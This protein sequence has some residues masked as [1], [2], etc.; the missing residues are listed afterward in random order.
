[1]RASAAVLLGIALVLV[2]GSGD[3][4]KL[5]RCE[6]VSALK[7]HGITSDLRNWVCLVESES[8]GRTDKR[9][10]RNKN[11]SY[12]YGLFQINSKYWCGIGKVAGDCR[13]KCEDLLNNDL[14][15]DV[16]CA[17]KIFQ[18]HGFRGW[19]GWRNKCD[20]KSLPDVSRC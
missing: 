16:R 18:R 7:R 14:S 13:L 6:I 19:Y 9:G 5:Q 8:G 11:G 1:M 4:K 15:D 12:D 20:G 3:A 17:K 10:P 2:L